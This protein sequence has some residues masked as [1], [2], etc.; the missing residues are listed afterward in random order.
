MRILHMIPDIGVSNGVMSVILNYAKAMPSDIKFDVVYFHETQQTRQADIEA[1]GGSVYKISKPSLSS[2]FTFQVYRFLKEHRGEW[3]GLHIHCPHFAV[4]IAPF[5]KLVGIKNIYVQCHTTV[6][7]LKGNIHSL[8]N[9]VL[10]LYAKYRVSGRLACSLAAGRV[11]YKRKGFE[12]VRSG[13]DSERFKYNEN[14]RQKIREEL[15]IEGKFAV[16]HIGRTDVAQ[17]NHPFL[18][19]VFAEI[20]KKNKDSV[21]LLVGAEETP[22]LKSLAEELSISDSVI[23][24][25]IRDDIDALLQGMDLFL[26]PSTSEGLPVSVVE[27]QAAGLPVLMSKSITSETVVLRNLVTL[28]SLDD[29]CEDWA[30]AAFK[31]ADVKRRDTNYEIKE[32]GWDINQCAKSLVVDYRAKW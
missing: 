28:K 1:L 23:Y 17:K 19:K 26:F 10:G 16:G 14:T 22:S 25:G 5:A 12:I 3:E 2:V 24:L 11:W 13:V 29:S 6:F 27:A 4:F 7:S 15:K 32:S 30:Q 18:F 8:I 31:A 9:R 20:K 21:L